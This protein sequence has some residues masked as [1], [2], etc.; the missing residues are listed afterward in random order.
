[1]FTIPVTIRDVASHCGV[2]ISTVSRALNKYTDI[3]HETK[4]RVLASVEELGYIPNIIGR[5]LSSKNSKGIGFIV[6]GLLDIN[7]HDNQWSLILQGIY[8]FALEKG[9]EV[10]I[11]TNDSS[12]GNQRT[13]E[14]FCRERS[15]AGAVLCGITTKDAYFRTLMATEIPCVLIDVPIVGKQTGCVSIDNV[16]ASRDIAEYLISL[17]HSKFLIIAGKKDA[18][19]TLER[20]A[21]TNASFSDHNIKLTNEIVE[22]C[23]FNEAMA[24]DAVMKHLKTYGKT[25]TDA[26]ICMSDVM[27]LGVLRAIADCG[28][29]VPEDFSVTG[30]DDIAIAQYARPALTTVRQDATA[31]GYQGARLLKKIIENP[32]NAKHVFLPHQLIVRDSTR[33]I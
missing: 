4:E 16:E 30:F 3:S 12:V 29:S 20:I 15:L 7:R 32:E 5:G 14:Q 13:Y 11:Y 33:K 8:K 28:Y 31:S 19:V 10:S 22:Y 27:A 1:M 23:D 24:Y 9:L 25:Q 6:S 21:G 26:F 17:N 2:S 18:A